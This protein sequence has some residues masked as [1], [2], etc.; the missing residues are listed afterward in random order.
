MPE[1]SCLGVLVWTPVISS[2]YVVALLD[3][4]MIGSAGPHGGGYL[5]TRRHCG[6]QLATKEYQPG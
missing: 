2:T 1:F 3:P 6:A 5:R 4:D